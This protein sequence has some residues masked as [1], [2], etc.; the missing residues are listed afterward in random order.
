MDPN[1]LSEENRRRIEREMAIKLKKQREAEEARNKMY[2]CDYNKCGKIFTNYGI[3][4]KHRKTHIKK[5]RC[6]YIHIGCNREFA[7]E[8]DLK[9]HQRIHSKEKSEICKF[10]LR[11]FTDPAALRKHI[12]YIHKNDIININPFH[13]K[14]CN[15]SFQRK[16]SLQKHWKTHIKD[17]EKKKSFCQICNKSFTFKWN[18]AK[19]ERLYH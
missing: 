17:S 2:I 1:R 7:T 13:C 12:K 8:K 19:H 3:Y 4:N 6:S 16:D 11:G 18:Y 14:Q 5:Y 9:I 10:C 15:K